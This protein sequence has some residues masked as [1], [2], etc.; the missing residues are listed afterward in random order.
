MCGVG[1]KKVVDTENYPC[2][3]CVCGKSVEST[4]SYIVW[5]AQHGCTSIVVASAG[6]FWA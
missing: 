6:I 5:Y 2:V 1:L 3:G 4:P